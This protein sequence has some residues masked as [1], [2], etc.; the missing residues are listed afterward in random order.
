MPGPLPDI[1]RKSAKAFMN[2]EEDRRTHR[3]EA[4]DAI[5]FAGAHAKIRYDARHIPLEFQVGQEVYLRL[6][7]GY[8]LP[9]KAN[10]NMGYQRVGPFKIVRKAGPLAYEIKLPSHLKFHP[11]I[12]IAQLEPY[13]PDPWN[14]SRPGL[15]QG[16]EVEGDTDEW[17]SYEIEKLINRRIKTLPN[18]E[19]R[20]QY[21]VKW[22][23]A[24]PE[25][26]EWH[27]AELLSHAQEAIQDYETKHVPIELAPKA[28]EIVEEAGLRRSSRQRR[29][30]DRKGSASK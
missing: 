13:V 4:A 27:D 24:G 3:Q 18:G 29:P 6:H 5:A 2:F 19:Q 22:K 26:S 10:R 15:P 11:V 20:V 9:E 21:M 17:K 16:I 12:S 8:N 28:R 25:W 7:H 30:T 1:Q 23:N 14:R